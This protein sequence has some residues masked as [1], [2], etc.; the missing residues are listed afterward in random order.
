MLVNDWSVRICWRGIS[1]EF[2]GVLMKVWLILWYFQMRWKFQDHIFNSHQEIIGCF[3]R[4][5]LDTL[6]QGRPVGGDQF[7]QRVSH[8]QYCILWNFFWRVR[9]CNTPGFYVETRRV[10]IWS[11]LSQQYSLSWSRFYQSVVLKNLIEVPVNQ[12]GC[13]WLG[14]TMVLR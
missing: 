6:I 2:W 4:L 14:I 12:D 5:I 10:I 7:L 13:C 8:V 3:G 1:R 9:R 11:G